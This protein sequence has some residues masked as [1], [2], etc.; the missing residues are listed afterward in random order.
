[1]KK[2]FL[3]IFLALEMSG[4]ATLTKPGGV[5]YHSS[6]KVK[7]SRAVTLLEQGKTMAAA[8]LLA[9]ICAD[10]GVPGVT[11]EALFRLSLLQLESNQEKNGTIKAQNNLERLQKEYPSSSWTPLASSLSE[12]LSTT[13]D[14]RQQN[15]KFEELNL[16]LT[17]EQRVFKEQK[18]S[19]A[20]E[21]SDLKEQ[22]LS[23]TKENLELRQGIEKLKALELELAKGRGK[24][25]TQ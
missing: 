24:P 25:G 9:A 10:P 2:S 5:L 3:I 12:F 21:N 13:D 8:E 20:K 11:D 1:M 23:L 7:L 6:Q 15:R 19:L 14:V 17:K 16:S 18:R 4:C 22:N